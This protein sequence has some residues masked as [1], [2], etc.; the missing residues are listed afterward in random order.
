MRAEGWQ[1]E[2]R[3]SR[4]RN[5][6]EEHLLLAFQRAEQAAGDQHLAIGRE[7]HVMRLI[8]GCAGVGERDGRDY[9]SVVMRMLIE[10]DDGQEVGFSTGLI[11][12]P[13]VE[14]R[15]LP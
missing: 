14:D 12:G 15:L 6:K 9:L 1:E 4:I 7:T 5:V 11:A 10:I 13:D 8:A 3:C 2:F